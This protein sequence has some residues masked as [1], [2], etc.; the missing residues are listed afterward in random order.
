MSRIHLLLSFTAILILTFAACSDDPGCDI[1]QSDIEYSDNRIFTIFR[2]SVSA[3][4]LFKDAENVK[5][6]LLNTNSLKSMVFDGSIRKENPE[7]L[8][9]GIVICR[10]SIGL[11]DIPDG[12]YLLI[13]YGDGISNMILRKI[14]FENSIGTEEE[15]KPMAYVGLEGDGTKDNP[16]KINDSGDFLMFA[17]TLQEDPDHAFGQYFRQTSSFD[18]PARSMIIDGKVWAPCAFSGYYDG[19]G[20]ELSRLTY[21]GASDNE[22]DRSIGLFSHL[23]S[24]YVG[25]LKLTQALITNVTSDIGILA[26][27]T[28]GSTTVENVSVEGSLIATGN[29]IGG[30]IGNVSD[31]LVLNSISLNTLSVSGSENSSCNVGAI[32]GYA[33]GSSIYI[34]GVST[35]N[36]IFSV[37]GYENVGGVAGKIDSGTKINFSNIMLEHTVD[38]ESSNVKVVFASNAYAGGIAGWLEPEDGSGMKNISLKCPVKCVQDAGGLSGHAYVRGTF[39]LEKIILS[40][41]VSGEASTGGFFGY[42]N[43]A[44]SGSHLEFNGTDNST[45]YVVKSSAAA[46]VSGGRHVGGIIG[47]FEA[48]KGSIHFNSKIEIAVNVYGVSDNVGGAFGFVRNITQDIEKI[49]FSSSTM[50]VEGC[51]QAIGGIAGYAENCT[52]KGTNSL[53]LIKH[54]PN[55]DELTDSF[56]GVVSGE[57]KTGGI[58]GILKGDIRG[59]SSSA[60]VTATATD[61]GGIVGEINGSLSS[62]A[63]KGTVATPARG[64]IAAYC[65]HK[66]NISNCV[67]LADITSGNWQ[68][69]IIAYVNA[70]QN[71]KVSV[72]RCVNMGNLTGG[73]A[74][75]GIGGYFSGDKSVA[76]A[77]STPSITECA[78]YGNIY[79]AGNSESPVGGIV[80]RI[81][82]KEIYTPFRGCANHGDVGSSN[83]QF[84]IGGVVGEIGASGDSNQF[85]V[86]QCMNSGRIFC[87]VSSTKLG[88]VAGYL[89]A[90]NMVHHEAIIKDC[91][92]TGNIDCNQKDDTGGILAYA[93]HD[94]NTYRTFNRGKISHGN[95][96]IGTHAGGSVFYHSH[97]YYLEGTGGSWPSSTSVKKE[98]IGKESSYNDFDFTNVWE[99]TPDGPVL[100][101]CP[102][103]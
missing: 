5:F 52:I 10:M 38:A 53:D 67:N 63:F 90:G 95:A 86:E 6:E 55:A 45:R 37:T 66:V 62:C 79:A 41:V 58:A 42:L 44:N 101:H 73:T 93:S 56:H 7:S 97:N 40:S 57:R 24:A 20:N 76:I 65:H 88:G 70:G 64:G 28:S 18:V 30:L 78:N 48:N 8:N 89:H 22:T 13:V 82:F 19:G 32:I 68:A 77:T 2:L 36:H 96:I 94:T 54:I 16:Y 85:V 87:D 83:V 100:R 39:K 69:G 91:Y 34:S 99:I 84:A 14:R 75:G 74:V 1:R 51:G 50:R 4:N 103:Q 9:N 35:P 25:N 60:S 43:L 98:N 3:D 71:C 29:N 11:S 23:F 61:A 21:Q 12:N 102:F 17:A 47:F 72:N 26:G 81:D 92:N 33:K 27:M 46:E 31:N 49:N 80:A 59:A 15:Y